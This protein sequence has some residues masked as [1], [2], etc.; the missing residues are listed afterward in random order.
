LTALQEVEDALSSERHQRELLRS[1]RE[2]LAAAEDALSESKSRY[3]NGLSDYLRVLVALQTTQ[4]LERS[5][6]SEERQL[7]EFRNQL[8]L[9]L[10]GRLPSVHEPAAG[11]IAESEDHSDNK[12]NTE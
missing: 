10:G 5:V 7:R 2:Q 3:V 11:E 6:I 8:L 4:N 9:A 1:L 12:E